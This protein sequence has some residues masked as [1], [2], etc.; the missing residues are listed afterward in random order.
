MI[1]DKAAARRLSGFIISDKAAA[2]QLLFIL[3]PML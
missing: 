2:S 3:L 1:N